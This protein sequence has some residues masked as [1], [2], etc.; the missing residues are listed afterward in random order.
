MAKGPRVQ[1]SMESPLTMPPQGL[2]LNE[3]GDESGVIAPQARNFVFLSHRS[4][5]ISLFFFHFLLIRRLARLS[6]GVLGGGGA[7]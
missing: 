4:V 5:E 6:F 3:Y 1:R 2:N 7:K